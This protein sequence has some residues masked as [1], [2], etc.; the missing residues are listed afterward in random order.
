[1]NFKVNP[2]ITAGFF[3]RAV[4]FIIDSIIIAVISSPVTLSLWA[5]D[6]FNA[7]VFFEMS[8]MAI[9]QAVLSAAYFTLFTTYCGTTPGKALFRLRVIDCGGKLTIINV[10]Y[11][12]TIGRYLNGIVFIGYI[13]V[14]FDK[15]HCTLADKLCDTRVVYPN[16]YITGN[17]T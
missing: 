6:L 17:Y 11:R 8:V 12:E 1:M 13:M 2:S 16:F 3:V 10:L 9:A 7:P 14:L 5:V 4:A 15:E